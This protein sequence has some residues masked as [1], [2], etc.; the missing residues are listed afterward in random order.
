MYNFTE[1]E[2]V[3]IWLMA[4]GA[5]NQMKIHHNVG[6]YERLKKQ[7]IVYPNPSFN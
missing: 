7:E 3:R 6:Y 5:A 2:R 4:S 1:E